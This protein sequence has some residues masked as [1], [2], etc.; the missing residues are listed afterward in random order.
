MRR[1]PCGPAQPK[2]SGLA[3]S[4]W[5]DKFA[6]KLNGKPIALK[7]YERSRSLAIAPDASRF[8]LGTE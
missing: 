3:V 5:E 4:D 7:D 1:S 6:P 8:V 2:T